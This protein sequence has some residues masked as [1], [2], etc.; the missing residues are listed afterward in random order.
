MG[1]IKLMLSSM[2]GSVGE[3]IVQRTSLGRQVKED[4]E[5]AT[6]GNFKAL[7]TRI[8]FEQGD[9]LRNEQQL[10][11]VVSDAATE[12]AVLLIR[13]GPYDATYTV[14]VSY[15]GP[16][17]VTILGGFARLTSGDFPIEWDSSDSKKCSF[18]V[19]RRGG[20]IWSAASKA[21]GTEVEEDLEEKYEVEFLGDGPE[22]GFKGR[23]QRTHEGGLSIRGRVAKE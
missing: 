15:N 2:A 4:I 11:D 9:E 6:D 21:A 17:N 14:N 13:G 12:A 16:R 8:I 7:G 23:F 5:K 10:L 22:D 18:T 1:D 20:T 19:H 3:A